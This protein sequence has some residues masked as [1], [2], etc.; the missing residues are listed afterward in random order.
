MVEDGKEPLKQARKEHKPPGRKQMWALWI[1]IATALGSQGI[2]KIVELLENKPS[3]EQVQTMIAKQT[4]ELTQAQRA[5]VDAFKDLDERLDALATA[6][7]EHRTITGQLE[8]RTEIFK[9]ILWD[10]CTRSRARKRLERLEE[11]PRPADRVPTVSHGK[12][13]PVSEERILEMILKKLGEEG[14]ADKVKKVPE[15][16]MQQQLQIQEPLEE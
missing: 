16:N 5:S 11:S 1:A 15:F 6:C 4:G 9:E 3:V 2:P 7:G 13:P 10:C 12:S 14:A 8:E